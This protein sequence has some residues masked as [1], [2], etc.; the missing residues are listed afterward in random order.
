MIDV[1][2]IRAVNF[3]AKGTSATSHCSANVTDPN[4]AE[5]TF[6]ERFTRNL[7]PLSTFHLPIHPRLMAGERQNI[8][9]HAVRDGQGE[10]VCGAADFYLITGAGLG[11]DRIDA[12]P[13][14]GD[15][16]EARRACLDHAFRIAVISTNGTI[17]LTR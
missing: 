17:E 11:V 10:R 5:C 8:A 6:T 16:F 3:H 13:P 7:F 12:G 9:E 14:L 2:N 15:D 1:N 4:Y